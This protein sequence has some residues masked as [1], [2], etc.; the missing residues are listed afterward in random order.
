VVEF[1]RGK[2]LLLIVDNCEH[3]LDQAAE[4]IEAVVARCSD[5]RVLATSLE[6]IGI[7]GERLHPLRSLSMAPSSAALEAVVVTDAVELFLDR[8][9]LVAPDFMIDGNNANAVADICR[10]LDGIPL[11]IELAAARMGAMSPAEIASLLDER[12]RLLTGGRRRA[13]ER[14]HTLRAAVDWSYELLSEIDRKIFVR[15]GVFVGG[16]DAAAAQSVAAAGDVETFDV[17]ETLAEL[18]AKSMVVADPTQPT[19]RYS[20]L[21]TL[22]QYALEQLADAGQADDG[23][24][25]HADHYAR[26]AED[27]G[28]RLLGPEE[29]TWRPRLEQEIDNL[30]IAVGWALE[31]DV[32]DEA[33]LGMRIL[34]AISR[35]TVL[36]RRFGIGGWAERAI[37]AP[38][39]I[40]SPNRSTVMMVAGYGAF[41]LG[42]LETTDR[43]ARAVQEVDP[44]STWAR[45]AIANVQAQRGDVA[46]ALITLHAAAEIATSNV[47]DAHSVHSVIAIYTKIA[48]RHDEAQEAASRAVSLA[49]AQGQP[50]S[51]ALALYARGY[52]RAKVDPGAARSDLEESIRLVESGA[53]VVAL[54]NAKLALGELDF[55]E[56]EIASAANLC[57]EAIEIDDTSGDRPPMV[58]PLCL[59]IRLFHAV[60][61]NEA[62]G[63]TLGALFDGCFAPFSPMAVAVGALPDPILQE[64]QSDAFDRY[65]AG[66]ILGGTMSYD[67]LVDFLRRRLAALA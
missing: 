10:R 46:G 14:H 41:H 59:A 7:S 8:A 5:V 15:L 54:G 65:G 1:L 55:E 49:R 62:A 30:R 13:V 26:F 67:A 21:E 51:L 57:R 6:G 45:M 63:I 29:L 25:R 40:D 42:D 56:G 43:L 16:F 44:E 47:F 4:L 50:S 27:I 17:I 39:A 64:M 19:T 22:R 12:F 34:A 28:P 61:E 3:V 31:R 11:A 37:D 9:L 58:G 38:G 18:V 23:R 24:R 36:S 53:G 66:R 48:G 35:E 20:L 32:A 33:E 2:Q 60:A 52:A